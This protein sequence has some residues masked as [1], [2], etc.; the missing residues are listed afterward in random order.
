MNSI[1]KKSTEFHGIRLKNRFSKFR[2][3]QEISGYKNRR[4]T[5]KVQ[6]SPRKNILIIQQNFQSSLP[7]EFI[8]QNKTAKA[9]NVEFYLL[10]S[11]SSQFDILLF[12]FILPGET[13]SKLNLIGWKLSKNGTNHCCNE[14]NL[15]WTWSHQVAM[16]IHFKHFLNW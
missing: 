16:N 14:S 4:I 8:S 15:S 6:K 9:L 2:E 5:S 12:D 10:D 7:M 1:W 3:S 13:N 11:N